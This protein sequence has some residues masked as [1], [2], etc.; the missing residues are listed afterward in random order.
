MKL[1]L[2]DCLEKMRYIKTNCIQLT[3]TS[4]P[5]DNLRTYNDSLDWGEHVWKPVL[6]ELFRITKPSGVVVW[7]I[8]DAS[9]DGSETGTS[10]R[11]ALYAMKI[12][13]RLHDTMIY[14]KSRV[15]SYNPICN[16]YWQAFDYMFV[17][18][19]GKP[20]CNYIRTLCKFG[21]RIKRGN[22]GERK[23]T[24]LV[25]PIE[26]HLINVDRP[27]N[28]IWKYGVIKNHGHPAVFPL[29]LAEDHV[30]SWSNEHDLVLDPLMGSGTTGVAAKRLK[31][32]FVGIEKVP[33]Y[34]Q[35]AKNL[36]NETRIIQTIRRKKCV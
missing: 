27:I 18:S 14:E 2:G 10:F 4:P 16:R 6:K 20:M 33:E 1:I 7:I 12:G 8:G 3:V 5:Y 35:I 23:P 21:G 19:K 31:R 24:G 11:Q 15:K 26:T 13:F 25:M 34:F 22:F 17:F 32:R 30:R 36:I 28:N 9:I 29:R